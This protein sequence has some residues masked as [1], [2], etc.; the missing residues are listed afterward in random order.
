LRPLENFKEN[1]ENRINAKIKPAVDLKRFLVKLFMFLML[2]YSLSACVYFL[3]DENRLTD[4]NAKIFVDDLFKSDLVIHQPVCEDRREVFQRILQHQKKHFT[5]LFLG[6]SR[7]LQFGK[8]TGYEN[9]LNLGLLGAS[10]EDILITDSLVN[11]YGISADTV[12]FEFSPWF[13]DSGNDNRYRQFLFNENTTDAVKRIL[14]FDHGWNNLETC[15]PKWINNYQVFKEVSH[16]ENF[17]RKFSD[18]SSA[19]KPISSKKRKLEI[20]HFVTALY[21]MKD[22]Y[23]IHYNRLELYLNVVKRTS[24]K[25]RTFV[26]LSPFHADLFHQ[27]PKDKRV[28]NILKSEMLLKSKLPQKA[29]VIGSFNPNMGGF[30]DTDFMDGFHI[31]DEALRTKLRLH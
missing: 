25:Q 29:R 1:I 27:K 26:V 20:E 7:I 9:A 12:I 10:L 23:K 24:Q 21:Q 8:Y 3:S 22:F 30:H 6:S 2:F 4:R 17:R 28:L 18:G 19:R 16:P 15:F 5:Y 31:T 13:V 14:Q 11:H